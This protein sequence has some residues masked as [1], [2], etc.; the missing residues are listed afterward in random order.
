MEPI[1]DYSAVVDSLRIEFFNNSNLL[2]LIKSATPQ[3]NE[4]ETQGFEL[5]ENRWL[6]TAVGAQLDILGEILSLGRSGRER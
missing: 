1:P 4:V 5:I 3:A 2:E 6:D